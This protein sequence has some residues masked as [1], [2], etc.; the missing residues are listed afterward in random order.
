MGDKRRPESI[1][2]KQGGSR[3]MEKQEPWLDQDGK[4]VGFSR[5]ERKGQY[6]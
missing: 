4:Q 6:G 3:G 2:T 5:E 1:P